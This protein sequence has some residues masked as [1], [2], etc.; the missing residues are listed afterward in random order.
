M[1]GDCFFFFWTNFQCFSFGVASPKSSV[2]G[3]PSSSTP[4]V[5]NAYI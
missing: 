1:V 3:I 4:V 2:C 5:C